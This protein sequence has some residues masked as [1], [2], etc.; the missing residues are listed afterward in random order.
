MKRLLSL[1]GLTTGALFLSSCV[2]TPYETAFNACEAEADRCYRICE[3]IPDERGYI[4][5]QSHCDSTANRC[6]DQARL[7]YQT[8]Y[9]GYGNLGYGPGFG[10]PWYGRYGS[11]YPSYG[12]FYDYRAFDRYGYRRLRA[13]PPGYRLPAYRPPGGF[14]QQ[15]RGPR[16]GY[17]QP[18]RGDN[19]P[20][21]GN[22]QPPVTQPP[23]GQPASPPPR[24]FDS[25]PGRRSGDRLDRDR[26]RSQSGPRTQPQP[27]SGYTPPAQSAPRPSYS[28]P[29][30]P[31]P[32]PNYTPPPQAA[33]QPSYTP[34]PSSPA[35]APQPRYTPPPRSSE[36]G[37]Q[38]PPSPREPRPQEQPQ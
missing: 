37:R 7:A 11:W 35:P 2:T 34:P 30:Q 21:R 22:Y 38:R 6:F 23:A 33:P 19:P 25:V 16:G 27:Q 29:P 31:A 1:A 8:Q 24:D 26:R 3:D 12:F 36:D 20:P 28:P 15:P 9:Y 10:A 14:Y 4:Q 18:R 32:Q 17:G 5:C 13:H